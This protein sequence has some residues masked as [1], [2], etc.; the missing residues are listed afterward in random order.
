MR[1]VSFIYVMLFVFSASKA[2]TEI[3][4]NTESLDSVFN[5]AGSSIEKEAE[6]TIF[7][8]PKINNKT[9][10]KCITV[11][12]SCTSGSGCVVD[13]IKVS[14]GPGSADNIS[15]GSNRIVCSDYRGVIGG[16]YAYI[17][18]I[19]KKYCNGKFHL[20]EG[21]ENGVAVNVY[22]HTCKISY[23]SEY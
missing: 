22:S 20:S 14:S 16:E 12:A 3:I 7:F 11:Q 5:D 23:V 19:G 13:D 17:M 4:V 10:A 18:R 8:K 9:R 6:E 1:C 21:V 2:S 15:Q